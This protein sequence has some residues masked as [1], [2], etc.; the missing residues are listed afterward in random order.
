MPKVMKK[1]PGTT[2]SMKDPIGGYVLFLSKAV[3]QLKGKATQS[4]SNTQI[5]QILDRYVTVGQNLK[6]IEVTL[7]IAGCVQIFSTTE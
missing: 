3:A 1:V 7:K 4:I 2:W 5:L 6:N